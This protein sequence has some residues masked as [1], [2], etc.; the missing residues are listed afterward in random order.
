MRCAGS[1]RAS[2]ATSA[3]YRDVFK[4]AGFQVGDLMSLDDL[5]KLPLTR[6][7]DYLAGIALD[8]PFG[9]FR[10]VDV[11]QCGACSLHVRY[12]WAAHAGA[13]DEG[14]SRALDRH[15][16]ALSLCAGPARGRRLPLHVQLSL[17]RR[18]PR[19]HA[20]RRAHRRTGHPRRRRRHQASDRDH[21][22][23]QAEGRRRHALVHGACRRDRRR[24]GS[25]SFANARSRWSASAASRAPASPA[26]ARGSKR[27]GA[28]S[29]TTAM[30]R[31]SSSRS[32]GRRACRPA[33]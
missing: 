27:C 24:D 33:R 17:V 16:C 30:A 12:H 22:A 9:T 19:F 14:R 21:P 18:R 8:P 1:S 6:K 31:P 13:V 25:R 15:L 7:E 26:R 5:R 32:R 10:A 2:R 23:V 20:G 28:R 29:S 11:A 3:H 4:S